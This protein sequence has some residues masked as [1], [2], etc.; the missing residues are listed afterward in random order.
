V[1]RLVHAGALLDVPLLDALIVTDPC[2]GG[3]YYSFRE[4][5]ALR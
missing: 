1:S 5:G 3:T 2:E 4:A